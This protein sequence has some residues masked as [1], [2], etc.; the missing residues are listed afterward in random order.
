MYIKG[1]LQVYFLRLK[2]TQVDYTVQIKACIKLKPFP[3]VALSAKVIV[4]VPLIFNAHM[5]G[6]HWQ[7]TPH[8]SWP[9]SSPVQKCCRRK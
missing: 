8:F 1:Q 5:V 7:Y 6:A 9:S 2:L 4:Q 3:E